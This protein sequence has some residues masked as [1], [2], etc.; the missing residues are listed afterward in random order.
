MRFKPG[1]LYKIAADDKVLFRTKST[2]Q[3]W[4]AENGD[5]MMCI[6]RTHFWVDSYTRRKVWLCLI[7]EQLFWL[8]KEDQICSFQEQFIEL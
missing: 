8:S 7:D 5:I 1:K 4:T 6:E 3:P 2:N